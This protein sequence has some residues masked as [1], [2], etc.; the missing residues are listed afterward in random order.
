[1]ERRIVTMAL[2]GCD[3]AGQGPAL[4]GGFLEKLLDRGIEALA[5]EAEQLAVVLEAEPEHFTGVN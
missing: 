3:H 4:L 1:V 2:Q 5:Q